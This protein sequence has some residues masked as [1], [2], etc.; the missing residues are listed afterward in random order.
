MTHAGRC[1]VACLLGGL[2]MVAC[3]DDGGVEV[4]T[5]TCITVSNLSTLTIDE[6]NFTVC[7]VSGWGAN[8]LGSGEI[9]PGEQRSWAV[10]AGC[11]DIQAVAEVD[12]WF[13]GHARYGADIP[14][15][16]THVFEFHGCPDGGMR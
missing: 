1:A 10:T 3:G 12:G 13:C 14:D 11:Y 6:V 2:S 4:C 8:H 16:T 7:G 15:G 9:A 5:G